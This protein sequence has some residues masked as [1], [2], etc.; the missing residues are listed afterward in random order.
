MGT[1]DKPYL[2]SA[3]CFTQ[4]HTPCHCCST[5]SGRPGL[6][7]AEGAHWRSDSAELGRTK[8]WFL[9]AA[10]AGRCAAGAPP[11]DASSSLPSSASA[12]ARAFFSRLGLRPAQ[13]KC[14]EAH[15]LQCAACA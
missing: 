14:H 3:C 5:T 8:V 6:L 15:M 7:D 9:R 13:D 12:A 4:R 2:L 10:G 11:S 1:Q